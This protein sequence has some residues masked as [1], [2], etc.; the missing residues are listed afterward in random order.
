MAHRNVI[1]DDRFGK[2][3]ADVDRQIT[4][5]LLEA[6]EIVAELARAA[7]SPSGYKIAGIQAKTFP[8]LAVYHTRRGLAV[9]IVNK[10]FRG[11]W[12]EK[13][14]Y[15]RHKGALKKATLARRQTPSGK[16]RAARW[17]GN[18]GVIAQKFMRRGLT[19]GRKVLMD[20]IKANLP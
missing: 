2:Y 6:A 17:K 7:P 1:V 11:L 13:G 14:T 18:G 3:S 4:T 20:R 9:D 16:R 19:S 12:F 5:A 10:D 8:R 15:S